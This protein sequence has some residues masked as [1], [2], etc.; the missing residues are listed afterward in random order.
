MR[1]IDHILVFHYFLK[2]K[3]NFLNSF[4]KT[5][6]TLE[7]VSKHAQ[8]TQSQLERPGSPGSKPGNVSVM[9]GGQGGVLLVTS[10][11]TEQHP[12]QRMARTLC[13]SHVIGSPPGTR[14]L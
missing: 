13:Q 11:E 14:R 3:G 9:T 7:R 8:S 1:V 2:E 6:L 5:Y 12:L 4:F 10:E